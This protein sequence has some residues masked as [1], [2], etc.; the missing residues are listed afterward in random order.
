MGEFRRAINDFNR[1][2]MLNREYGD[3]YNDRGYA[4]FCLG[5]YGS[6]VND[7][8]SAI[9]LNPDDEQA[10]INLEKARRRGKEQREAENRRR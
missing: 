3:A 10:R 7:F 1:A 4:Q 2:I 8:E 5:D 9:R 6:A